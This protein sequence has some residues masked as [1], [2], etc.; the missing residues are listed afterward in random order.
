VKR[1]AFLMIAA[2]ALSACSML[3]TAEL[4]S[5]SESAES[6]QA[7]S[8][9]LINDH[10]RSR[11]IALDF[12][13]AMVQLPEL[14]PSSTTLYTALPKSRFAQVLILAMQDA[15]YD[16]R[17]GNTAEP[18]YLDYSIVPREHSPVA[19]QAR[20]SFLI[21]VASVKLKRD[22][23]VDASGVYPTSSMFLHG[24]DAGQLALSNQIF[25]RQSA[26]L[27]SKP[28][29]RRAPAPAAAAG[30]RP[31]V[32]VAAIGI[33]K[34]ARRLPSAGAIEQAAETAPPRKASRNNLAKG[35]VQDKKNLFVTRQSNFQ[36][37][38]KNYAV[39]RKE[40]LIFPN[41]SI[42]MLGVGLQP[43]LT[44]CPHEVLW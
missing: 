40:V 18:V 19:D 15:G 44:R 32:Q 37:V 31:N 26:Q 24:S 21:S 12:V 7:G 33:R 34:Q 4:A 25:A 17:I 41:D 36:E 22:Y 39:L 43:T 10:A 8:E 27:V 29:N 11:L 3:P 13:E 1:L 35:V 38:L 6:G 9:A 23:R 42:R 28:V 5:D 14:P 30:Q 16:L 2:L 20:Y